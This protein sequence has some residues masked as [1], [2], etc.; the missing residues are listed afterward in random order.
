MNGVAIAEDNFVPRRNAH[1]YFTRHKNLKF[2]LRNY[3]S[4]LIA[5]CDRTSKGR[6]KK[7]DSEFKKT[8]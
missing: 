1:S 5:L 3:K 6:R 7:E 8:L 4:E 2:V